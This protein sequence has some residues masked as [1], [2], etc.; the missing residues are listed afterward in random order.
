MF[1]ILFKLLLLLMLNISFSRADG[2]VGSLNSMMETI[3]SEFNSSNSRNQSKNRDMDVCDRNFQPNSLQLLQCKV[4]ETMKKVNLKILGKETAWHEKIVDKLVNEQLTWS[5]ALKEI[6]SGFSEINSPRRR[7]RRSLIETCFHLMAHLNA[8]NKLLV[9]GS[10]TK[11]YN[12]SHVSS[13]LAEVTEALDNIVYDE[14]V[15]KFVTHQMERMNTEIA[16]LD[17][18]LIWH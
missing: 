12:V 15:Q 13:L 10:Q 16:K 9:N 3:S 7:K 14:Q 8:V 17:E 1:Q 11:I 18:L 4:I 6:S 2:L 5:E